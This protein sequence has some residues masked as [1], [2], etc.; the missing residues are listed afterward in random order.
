MGLIPADFL[1]VLCLVLGGATA[2]SID[3]MHRWLRAHG[4]THRQRPPTSPRA[5][6]GLLRDYRETC[7]SRQKPAR[8]VAVFW[9]SSVGAVVSGVAAFWWML[10]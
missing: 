9:L 4:E 5:T 6:L 3:R 7:R 8:L 2:W 1:M 10:F